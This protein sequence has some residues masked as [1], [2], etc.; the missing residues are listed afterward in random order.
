MYRSVLVTQIKETIN[1]QYSLLAKYD[2]WTQFLGFMEIVFA[3]VALSI[4]EY[5]TPELVLLIIFIVAEGLS[6]ILI[7]VVLVIFALLPLLCF[8]FCLFI[9]CCGNRE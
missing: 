3:I 8:L 5:N 7:I 4:G 2:G 9:C 1:Q 6:K